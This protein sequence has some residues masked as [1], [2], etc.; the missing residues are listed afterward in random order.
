MTESDC[1]AGSLTC[2]RA[3][4][5]PTRDAYVI[6]DAARTLPHTLWRRRT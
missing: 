5:R 3:P 6:A 1:C 4:P 2:T